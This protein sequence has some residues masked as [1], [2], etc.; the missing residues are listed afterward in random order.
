M[1]E[2]R[3]DQVAVTLDLGDIDLGPSVA[4]ITATDRTVEI[5]AH[6]NLGRLGDLTIGIDTDTL[7]GLLDRQ[8]EAQSGA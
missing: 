3:I 7:I 8:K 4:T 2:H 1:T 5:T 6:T